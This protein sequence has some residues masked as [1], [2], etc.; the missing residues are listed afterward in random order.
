MLLVS[1]V[2]LYC[3]AGTVFAIHLRQDLH[4][5]VMMEVMVIGGCI[6]WSNVVVVLSQLVLLASWCSCWI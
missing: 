1:K 4:G 2:T 6:L 5:I 3:V